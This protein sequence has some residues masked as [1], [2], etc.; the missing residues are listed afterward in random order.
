M[1]EKTMNPARLSKLRRIA[2]VRTNGAVLNPF[3]VVVQQS[4]TEIGRQLILVDVIVQLF[5]S[6]Q[7]KNLHRIYSALFNEHVFSLK[8]L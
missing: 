5:G 8:K 3:L 1:N 2:E 4:S 7:Y 6:V